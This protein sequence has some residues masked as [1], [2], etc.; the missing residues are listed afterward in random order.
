MEGAVGHRAVAE[1]RDRHAGVA[2][3]LRGRRC[4]H[5]DRQAGPH[6]PVGAEDADRRI[7]DVHRAPA[8]AIRA[9]LLGHQLGEHPERVETL[10]EAVTMAAMR[11]RDHVR[12]AEWPTRADGRCFLPDRQVDEARHLAVAVQ[13]SH[14]LLEPADHEHP[15]VHLDEVGVTEH[16][17]CIVLIGTNTGVG[18]G[19][20]RGDRHSN[21][22]RRR[23]GRDREARGR[24]PAPAGDSAAS[25]RTRSREAARS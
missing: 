1:E 11:G 8:P 2:P 23:C 10:R 15:P 19:D 7:G 16:R 14:A 20:G 12:R 6:D 18:R 22:L 13:R 17:A 24:S 25:S 5:R 3:Q 4:T 9:L 21:V